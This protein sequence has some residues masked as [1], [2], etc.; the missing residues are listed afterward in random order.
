MNADLTPL[1]KAVEPLWIQIQTLF[2][3]HHFITIV[4]GFF[5]LLMTISFYKFLRS[6]SPALVG[7]VL[8]LLV[9]VLVMHWTQT[10][11]EPV[12]LKPFIDGLAPFFPTVPSAKV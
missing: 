12:V 3:E 11:T 4:C 2:A 10:R 6:I 5:A 7:F 8:L 9:A 1:Q